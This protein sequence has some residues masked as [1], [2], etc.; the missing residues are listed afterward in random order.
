MV[1]AQ[2][3]C[4]ALAAAVAALWGGVAAGAWA[5]LGG[6]AVAAPQ[7]YFARASTRQLGEVDAASA[8]AEAAALLAR[9]FAKAAM[10]VGLAALGLGLAQG[11]EAAF[12]GGLV[13]ALAAQLAAPLLVGRTP[14]TG[15]TGRPADAGRG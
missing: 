2:A 15:R 13:A 9:W 4:S 8:R 12:L 5:L 10:T 7:A 11:R 3:A 1:L 14:G 6:M